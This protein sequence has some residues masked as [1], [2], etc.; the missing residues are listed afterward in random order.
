[1]NVSVGETF[2]L[3]A[4]SGGFR[5]WKVIGVYLGGNN[6]E[7]VVELETLDRLPCTEGRM[8]VPIEILDAAVH[9]RFDGT[10][11]KANLICLA[12]MIRDQANK[13]ERTRL[14]SDD[15]EFQRLVGILNMPDDRI[16]QVMADEVK[17]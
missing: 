10:D 15:E 9:E 3:R 16:V 13:L 8:C 17:R 11:V 12:R 6:Q 5:V 4:Y 14:Q 2:R 1:M 7:S